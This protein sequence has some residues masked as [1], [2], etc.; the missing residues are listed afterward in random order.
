MFVKRKQRKSQF[1]MTVVWISD[2]YYHKILRNLSLT[3]SKNCTI[4][5]WWCTSKS[6][7]KN[8]ATPRFST[9]FSVSGYQMKLCL[10]LFKLVNYSWSC[11]Q[12]P[13]NDNHLGQVDDPESSYLMKHQVK[14]HQVIIWGKTC[15]LSEIKH[16]RFNGVLLINT[17]HGN[18][19][20]P[21]ETF[22]C[23]ISYCFIWE[24]ITA[25]CFHLFLGVWNP[26]WNTL[27]RF[28]YY[29]KISIVS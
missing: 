9:H 3:F 25:L 26:W 19:E 16:L 24:D 18:S 29:T 23:I 8:S 22:H 28:T 6:V 27:P 17:T 11:S 20:I 4:N 15:F 13:I 5:D 7:F 21:E 2:N 14:H 10:S 1:T 12:K